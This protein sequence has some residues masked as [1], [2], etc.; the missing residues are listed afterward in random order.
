MKIEDEGE[1]VRIPTAGDVAAIE[2]PTFEWPESGFFNT[3]L[4][5]YKF[6]VSCLVQQLRMWELRWQANVLGALFWE[7]MKSIQMG[8]DMNQGKE[9]E[10]HPYGLNPVELTQEQLKHPPILALH[11]KNGTQGNF[12]SMAKAFQE[13]GV[14]PFFTLN[15]CEGELTM[16]D[17][18][19]I[20]G[21][22]QEIQALYG[23]KIEVDIIGY[24]RGAEM[25]LY[26]GLP[27]DSWHI[28]EGGYCYQDRE[29]DVMHSDIGRIFRIGSMTIQ[30]EWDKLS[31]EVRNRIY[32]A[33]GTEDILMKNLWPTIKLKSMKGMSD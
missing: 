30:T 21:K 6:G 15:L 29:W 31:E 12:L 28:K 16:E 22:I 26:M 11:G 1:L 14:G 9:K 8:R 4:E 3:L 19:R 32:E 20:D 27:T 23:R 17:Q 18:S 24:S 25:A 33:R 10:F 2:Y 7:P 5:I 13:A